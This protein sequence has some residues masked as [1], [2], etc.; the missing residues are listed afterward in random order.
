VG[1]SYH[2]YLQLPLASSPRIRLPIWRHLLR[3][4]RPVIVQRSLKLWSSARPVVIQSLGQCMCIILR[5]VSSKRVCKLP[6]HARHSEP[7]GRENREGNLQITGLAMSRHPSHAAVAA[8]PCFKR[9]LWQ[10]QRRPL[11]H[12]LMPVQVPS[13]LPR[14]FMSCLVLH[15]LFFPPS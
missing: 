15:Y 4:V 8:R 1:H 7:A 11:S 13:R 3:A 2:F 10:K 6:P 5:R 9:L 12:A 14:K